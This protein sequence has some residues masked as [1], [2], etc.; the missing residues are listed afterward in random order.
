MARA[1]KSQNRLKKKNK[2][3]QQ[4]R[5]V[6]L[7]RQNYTADA[8]SAAV[9]AVANQNMGVREAS[10]IYGVP[11]ATISDHVN[12][13]SKSNILGRGPILGHDVELLLVH[14]L[15]KLADWGFGF[16][17]SDLK[18]VIRDYIAATNV[19]NNFKDGL[20]GRKFAEL[21]K[22]RWRKELSVRM[23]QN[24]PKNRAEALTTENVNRFFANIIELY[25]SL[26]IFDKPQNIF[27]VDETGFCGDQGTKR[28]LCRKGSK[29]PAK[30]VG[31]NEKTMY[32][33]AMCCNAAG[34]YLPP[35]VVYK[36]KNLYDQWTGVDNSGPDG[37]AYSCSESGWMEFDT[38]KLWFQF[39][40]SQTSGIPGTYLVFNI[41]IYLTHHLFKV[42]KF[43]ISM[44]MSHMSH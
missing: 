39:F 26:E 20:P 10:S 35:F 21:F 23:A 43:Y 16:E 11:R 41:L 19:H 8:L 9:D 34:Q 12:G 1:N 42:L 6:P 27:N 37:A 36:S 13:K 5:K 22:K 2:K 30:I 25:K 15:T 38:F 40:I 4:P 44:A 24:V 29:N 17:V 3:V 32:T 33:V 31:N 14:A 28:I 18:V 7:S